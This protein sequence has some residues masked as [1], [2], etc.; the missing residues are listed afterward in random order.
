MISNRNIEIFQLAW[1]CT[2]QLQVVVNSC[3][4][5][6]FK[7]RGLNFWNLW[8][9]GNWNIYKLIVICRFG[10]HMEVADAWNDIMITICCTWSW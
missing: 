4:P 9:L 1:T 3:H 5:S 6:W 2:F 8:F 10:M 7:S